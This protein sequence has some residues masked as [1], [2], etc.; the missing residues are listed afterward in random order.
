MS[1]SRL[2]GSRLK[3]PEACP[4]DVWAMIMQCWSADVDVRFDFVRAQAA[5][6]KLQEKYPLPAQRRDL[7]KTIKEKV[8]D[9]P[10]MD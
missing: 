9:R 6:R 8:V 7:G 2:Q 4:P 5:I 10:D 3:Q 1:D